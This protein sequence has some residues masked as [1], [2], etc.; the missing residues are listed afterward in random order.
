MPEQFQHGERFGDSGVGI[1]LAQRLVEVRQAER[2]AHHLALVLDHD[3]QIR[4]DDG[5]QLHCQTIDLRV[6]QVTSHV[7]VLNP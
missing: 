1:G 2:G 5:L 6:V 4:V 3:D 7:L